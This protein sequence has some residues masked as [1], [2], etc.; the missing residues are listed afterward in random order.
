MSHCSSVDWSTLPA[1]ALPSDWRLTAAALG[2]LQPVGIIQKLMQNSNKLFCGMRI[3]VH[4]RS[5]PAALHDK[6]HTLL[7]GK[8]AAQ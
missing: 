8:E 5:K 4:I 2:P 1:A 3:K 6:L 7:I